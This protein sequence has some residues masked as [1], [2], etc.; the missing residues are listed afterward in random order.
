MRTNGF[1]GERFRI[2]AF[3]VLAFD[4]Q[5]RPYPKLKPQNAMS[6]ER[7]I[8]MIQSK[9]SPLPLVLSRRDIERLVRAIFGQE[10]LYETLT[11]F[12]HADFLF[13]Q[14][15][16]DGLSVEEARRMVAAVSFASTESVRIVVIDRFDQAT[17][18]A[19]NA[20][21]KILEDGIP[22]VFFALQADSFAGLLETIVSRVVLVSCD[23][24][25]I[26]G[27]NADTAMVRGILARDPEACKSYMMRRFAT[28]DEALTFLVSAKEVC[29]FRNRPDVLHEIAEVYGLVLGT[30]AQPKYLLD[31]VFMRML[32]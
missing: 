30:N 19:A 14:P 16:K 28:R 18:E 4:I 2:C 10:L 1:T 27:N 25:Q 12:A 3:S 15:E 20:L 22:G 32:E 6:L 7:Y 23:A 17:G 9:Q 5:Y 29:I 8:E 26:G 31:R 21:L 11:E 13:I 24:S